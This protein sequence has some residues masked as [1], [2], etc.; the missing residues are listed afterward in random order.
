VLTPAPQAD[1][2]ELPPPHWS[3]RDIE[4]GRA[5]CA[6]LLKGLDVVAH[7]AD[8][9][10]EGEA[11]GTPAPMQLVSIGSSP[12]ITFSPPA[13]LN[14][15]MI[16]ALHAW[17]Q[18][19]VQPLARQHLGTPVTGVRTM[20]SFSCR[21]AYGR[22]KTRLSEHG[23]VNAIDIGGFVTAEGDAQVIADWGPVGG[24]GATLVA[25][26]PADAVKRQAEAARKGKGQAK[27]DEAPRLAT[28]GLSTDRTYQAGTTIPMP[29]ITFGFR[30]G[31][32]DSSDISQGLG[33]APPS[34]LGGPKA[35]DATALQGRKTEFL[36]A[37]H[38]AACTIFSTV[39]GP[40]A[41]KAHRNH[42]HLDLAV[43]K[44]VT[45]CQ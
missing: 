33:W 20:S 6:V 4:E 2:S 15:E 5:R 44:S 45:I 28:P 37:I 17:L 27:P 10:R 38:K 34:R 31:G 3:A 43:R 26:A 9:I 30:T 23:R 8:P 40:D 11:C 16:V 32:D 13:T 41:D 24:E 1:P 14:C 22:A 25:R 7:P 42:F 18:R 29:T 39:L 19:D 35:A 12:R 21:N 36:H